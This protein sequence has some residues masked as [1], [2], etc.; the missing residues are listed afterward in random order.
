MSQ[1]NNFSQGPVP[2]SARK[3]ADVSAE[4]QASTSTTVEREGV[5]RALRFDV[6]T[7]FP[8]LFGPFTQAGVIRRAF[9]SGQVVLRLWNPRSTSPVGEAFGAGNTRRFVSLA[10]SPDGKR[11]AAADENLGPR[12]AVLLERGEC[13]A[14]YPARLGLRRETQG[15]VRV[16]CEAGGG[17]PAEAFFEYHVATFAQMVMPQHDGG[18]ERAAIKAG[19]HFVR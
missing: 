1:D 17:H 4:P 18:I 2:Q 7:L 5:A 15:L 19:E 3:G 6:I 9:D 10:V 13:N 14:S 11:L 12:D 16:V 8:E